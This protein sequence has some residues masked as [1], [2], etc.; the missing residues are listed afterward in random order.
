MKRTWT[1][2]DLQDCTGLLPHI[3]GERIADDRGLSIDA[4]NRFADY[5][6][7]RTLELFNT[8]T[9]FRRKLLH[10]YNARDTMYAFANH[11]LDGKQKPGRNYDPTMKAEHE[12]QT[13]IN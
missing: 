2:K 1:L 8:N 7:A 12:N 13:A 9:E 5:V 3:I 6:E 4:S 11:W 10:K